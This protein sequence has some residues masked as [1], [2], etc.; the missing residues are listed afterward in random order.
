[1]MFD[2]LEMHTHDLAELGFESRPL[3]LVNEKQW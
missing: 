1:M 2:L 3:F